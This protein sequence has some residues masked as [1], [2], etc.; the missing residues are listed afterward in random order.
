MVAMVFQSMSSVSDVFFLGRINNPNAQAALGFYGVL[1]G[2]LAA[3]NAIV[4]NGSVCVI[5]Q[6]YGA[7]RKVEAGLATVQTIIMK[8]FG[9]LL[10]VLPFFLLLRPL[11]VLFGAEA[12]ALEMSVQY[13]RIMLLVFPLLNTGYSFN[14]ALRAAGD[15]LTP[16]YLMLSTLII[17]LCFNVLFILGLGPF[18]QLGILG[19]ALSTAFAQIYLLFAG[20]WIYTKGKKT[21]SFSLSQLFVPRFDV[22]KKIFIIGLPTGFQ[23]LL[24][25]FANSLLIRIIALYGMQVV[26]AYIVV[27]RAAGISGM[28]ISGLSFATSAIV[29]QNMGANRPERSWQATVSAVWLAGGITALFFILFSLYPQ[30]ILGVFTSDSSLLHLAVPLLPLF[31]FLQ[32]TGALAG[33]FGAPLLGT[34]Y[35]KVSLYI[36][37]ISTWVFQ[38]PGMWLLGRY[39]GINGVW[40]S[41]VITSLVNLYLV[42]RVFKKK[43]WMI[44]VI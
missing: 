9:S 8:L 2:Y 39:F 10:L 7:G 41:F 38:I 27:T 1:T 25:G 21:I 24:A 34:G 22:M 13:G 6:Y 31:G 37:L 14:T 32:I 3:Y 23:G 20:L 5:S 19:V 4:G 17:N 12:E 43:S 18:P 42:V 16:M 36:S 40:L 29:G 44:K 35:L 30:V 11:M 28:L 15:S 33:I 26:A